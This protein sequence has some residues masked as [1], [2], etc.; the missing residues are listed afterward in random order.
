MHLPAVHK[1]GGIEPQ[2]GSEA[3]PVLA[4]TLLTD[5]PVTLRNVPRIKDVDVMC[6]VI[7]KHG[8]TVEWLGDDTVRI[9]AAGFDAT[10]LELTDTSQWDP[11]TVRPRELVFV[12]D[13]SCSMAGE[14]LAQAKE[15]MR[16][17]GIAV[18]DGRL[19]RSADDVPDAAAAI[20]YPVTLKA[21]GLAH[22]S[23][24]GA[25]KVGLADH[26]ALTAALTAMPASA[27][28][29]LVEATVTD[30]VAEVLVAV[31]R[32]HPVGWLVTL[33]HGGVA[34]EVWN[35]VT[36]LLAPVTHA[37]VV[38]MIGR[39]RS[40]PLLHGFRG[41]PP[42]DVDA[43]ADLVVRLADHVV[44]SGVVEAEL[45]PVL[46]GRHGAVA[47]DALLTLETQP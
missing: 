43:L 17:Y 9:C 6:Q 31:R 36:H 25:V 34:T 42:A 21:L 13:Q 23:E 18:P 5:Q 38:G 3:L 37:D 8:G 33:G 26:D 2:R 40:A 45:N 28:G 15:L 30:V 44:G 10:V 47:V 29:Y 20:G 19:V 11:A 7:E 41:R 24:A 35:D 12:I 27:V 22:K 32:D 16:K 4:A 1:G 46:V 39:L 14:P